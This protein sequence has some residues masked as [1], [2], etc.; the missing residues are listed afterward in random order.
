MQVLKIIALIFIGL[1]SNIQVAQNDPHLTLAIELMKNQKYKEALPELNQYLDNH[2]NSGLG[3][4]QR[5]TCYLMMQKPNIAVVDFNQA[6][7]LDTNITDVYFNRALAH[8]ALKNYTFAEA[9]FLIYLSKRPSAI[10][11]NLNLAMLMEEMA[12]YN[13][14][15]SYYNRYLQVYPKDIEALKS[16]ALTYSELGHLNMAL[17]DIESC[18][19]I[20]PNDTSIWML[21]GNICYDAQSYQSAIDAYNIILLNYP[22]TFRAL[23]NRAD[24]YMANKQF[25]QAVND[26]IRL[27]SM[28]PRNPE[29]HFNLG[30]CYLQLSKNSESVQSFSHAL[31]NEYENFGLLLM[32]RGVAYNNLKMSSEACADWN[33]SL[34]LG[35]KDAATYLDSYCK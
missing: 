34:A 3:Y 15:L 21:K 2:A 25:E 13:S 23:L 26:Y 5:G 11:T 7:R 9:D 18:F 28:D 4:F 31:D 33:K 30:F 27:L 12:D 8:Q 14:A 20:S 10:K 19:R 32:F 17:E 22:N 16:R 24:A 6:I 35:C 1:N 29:H